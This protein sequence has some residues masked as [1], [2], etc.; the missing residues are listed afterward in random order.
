[1]T[2]VDPAYLADLHRDDQGPARCRFLIRIAALYYSP[3]GRVSSLSE[4]LGFHPG[5]LAGTS[6]ITPEVAIKLEEL[7]GRDLFPRSLFRPDLFV[8]QD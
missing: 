2:V 8:L 4:A 7:L 1:M 5:T 6:T 3:E